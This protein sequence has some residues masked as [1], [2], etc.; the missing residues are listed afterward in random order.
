MGL[1]DWPHQSQGLMVRLCKAHAVMVPEGGELS[2]Q[3]VEF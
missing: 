2:N 1:R 3:S